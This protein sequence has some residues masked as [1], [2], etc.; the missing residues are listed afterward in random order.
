MPNT[1]ERV[2]AE[3]EEDRIAPVSFQVN[4]S[5]LLFF[6]E[7]CVYLEM[8]LKCWPTSALE[9]HMPAIREAIKKSMSDA[10]ADARV[11]ARK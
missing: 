11:Q 9:R 8:I 6:R 5:P 1:V 10:D 7:S 3:I 4:A 2:N